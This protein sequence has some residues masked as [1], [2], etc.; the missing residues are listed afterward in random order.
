MINKKY[1]IIALA[2][3]YSVFIQTLPN[4]TTNVIA[5]ILKKRRLALT[6]INFTSTSEDEPELP[7]EMEV[8]SCEQKQLRFLTLGG[9][10]ANGAGLDDAVNDAYPFLLCEGDS[11]ADNNM[12]PTD[13]ASCLKTLVGDNIYDVIVLDFYENADKDLDRLVKRLTN[14][15]PK[16]NVISVKHFYPNV[17]GFQ[18]RKGWASIKDWATGFGY[19][20]MSDDC[21]KA[22]NESGRPWELEFDA[23]LYE[24]YNNA[25][26]NNGIWSLQKDETL[27]YNERGDVIKD[28]VLRRWWLY[29][30]WDNYNQD[31]HRYIARG[32]FGMCDQ[33]DATRNTEDVVNPWDEDDA[34]CTQ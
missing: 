21:K 32:V 5:E 1:A 4:S 22:F 8:T 10:T 34:A 27:T 30:S 31:G 3:I 16:A 33:F 13:A 29:N 20:G 19:E 7:H 28:I 26:K 11:I 15:F 24:A 25:S 23:K 9:A 18:H 6:A 2:L 17:V 14:R 12:V